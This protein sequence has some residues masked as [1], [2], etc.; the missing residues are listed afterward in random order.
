MLVLPV[1]SPHY[2]GQNDDVKI[3]RSQS[4]N[5]SNSLSKASLPQ[6]ATDNMLSVMPL[7]GSG[8]SAAKRPKLSLQTLG[9][10]SLPSGR[11]LRTALKTT[12]DTES[13]NAD[14]TYART[15]EHP[16]SR[17]C[18]PTLVGESSNPQFHNQDSPACSGSST[19]TSNSG[20]TSPFPATAPYCL[21]I[22][23]HGILRNSPLP[24][25][26]TTSTTGRAAKV[27]FPLVKR[28][29]FRDPLVEIVPPYD[30]STDTDTSDPDTCDKRLEDE[31]AERQ[32]LDD[33]LEKESSTRPV[34]ARRKRRRD[35]WRLLEED[36]SASV[37][38]TE[39]SAGTI[40]YSKPE[41]RR[42]QTTPKAI[43]PFTEI[44]Q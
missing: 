14:D 4:Q 33:M 44:Q 6:Q 26:I 27:L 16:P 37:R 29:C 13:T 28:V 9:L 23:V 5:I 43:E 22:G 11:R 30:E 40:S 19:T 3:S 41:L 18:F 39:G 32:A 1:R 8:P 15:S 21:P 31:I 10:S 38:I 24:R 2:H 17:H 7:S 36:I 12:P 25:R 20:L 34:S 35:I 42:E